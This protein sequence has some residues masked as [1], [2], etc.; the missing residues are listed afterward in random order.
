MIIA[1]PKTNHLP[2]TRAT[3]GIPD[4]CHFQRMK[5]NSAK[6]GPHGK[7]DNSYI[8]MKY[9]EP[10][11]T[12]TSVIRTPLC[13]VQLTQLVR[14]RNPYKAYFSKTDTSIIR[15][16][17]PVP[18]VSVIKRLDCIVQMNYERKKELVRG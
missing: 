2:S 13:Y 15:T 1:C 6:D 12:D 10:L 7:M 14:D 11:L 9:V 16:L 8:Y 3:L 5:G 4:G 18:L 17:I